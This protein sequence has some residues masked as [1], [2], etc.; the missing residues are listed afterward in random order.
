MMRDGFRQALGQ[1]RLTSRGTSAPIANAERQRAQPGGQR[2]VAVYQ[3]QVLGQH[4]QAA[5]QGEEDD[6]HRCG[7]GGEGP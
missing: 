4:E 3:L 2:A 5:E 7:G 1:D 6:G